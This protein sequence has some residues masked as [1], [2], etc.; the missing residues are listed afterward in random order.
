MGEETCQFAACGANRGRLKF[1]FPKEI[2][3]REKEF[4]LLYGTFYL[5]FK[6]Q[7]GIKDY[8]ASSRRMKY[9]HGV[10]RYYPELDRQD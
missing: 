6:D 10:F 7:A 9:S 2:S 4:P 8:L 5:A 1:A 3:A